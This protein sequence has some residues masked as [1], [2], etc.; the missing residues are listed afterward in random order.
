MTATPEPPGQNNDQD[1]D[2]GED[3]MLFLTAEAALSSGAQVAAQVPRGA[4]PAVQA[5]PE[6]PVPYRAVQTA[7]RVLAGHLPG[8]TT[9]EV[10]ELAGRALVTALSEHGFRLVHQS[11]LDKILRET[12]QE[13]TAAETALRNLRG[14]LEHAMRPVPW[15]GPGGPGARRPAGG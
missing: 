14:Q 12:G 2:R 11:Y 4:G 9:E 10:T 3:I 7:A 5:V 13:I 1:E 6:V 8:M 15:A